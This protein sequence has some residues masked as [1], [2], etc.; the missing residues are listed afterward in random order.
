MKV[1]LQQ[2]LLHVW[3]LSFRIMIW[4]GRWWLMSVILA[5]QEAEIRRII[6]QCQPWQRVHETLSLKS[7][8]QKWAGGMAEDVGPEF[9]PQY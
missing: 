6:V 2:V 1:I 7:Q 9:I 3:S 4:A 8:S 5:T